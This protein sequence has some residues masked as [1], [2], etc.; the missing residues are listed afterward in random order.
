[1]KIGEEILFIGLTEQAQSKRSRLRTLQAL[2]RDGCT[3][4]W[5]EFSSL[6]AGDGIPQEIGDRARWISPTPY[7][8]E[9]RRR[10]RQEYPPFLDRFVRENGLWDLWTWRG[11]IGVWWL[12]PISEM[13]PMRTPLI[14]LLY[15]LQIIDQVLAE[16]RPKRVTLLTDDLAV[17]PAIRQLAQRYNAR[18]DGVIRAKR[19]RTLRQSLSQFPWLRRWWF[20]LQ[21]C[22]R[23]VVLRLTGIGKVVARDVAPTGPE[24]GAPGSA[25]GVPPPARSWA[26]FCTLFPSMW[27]FRQPGQWH[28]RS[29]GEW[30][31]FLEDHGYPPV[32]AA[33]TMTH[34]GKILFLS[35]QMRRQMTKSRIILLESQLTFLELLR[36]CFGNSCRRSYQ[37]WRRGRK[38]TAHFRGIEVGPLLMREIEHDI[39][40][41]EIPFNLCAA[42]AIR[43][44]A[45]RLGNI[46]C[47]T[48]PFEYQPTER[49]FTAGL[50]SAQ[51]SVPVIGLQTGLTG[52][53]HLGYRFPRG[54]IRQN[55]GDRNPRL[56]PL[57]DL[58]AVNG[59]TTL[60]ILQE[61]LAPKR[62]VLTG[63]VR[64]G[65]PR[66]LA[67]QGHQF[68]DGLKQWDIDLPKGCLPVLIAT[69]FLRTDSVAILRLAFEAG[70]AFPKTFFLIKDH[71][72]CPVRRE[73]ATIAARQGFHRYGMV[74]S[75]SSNLWSASRATITGTTSVGIEAIAFGS[76]PIVYDTARHYDQSP[77]WDIEEGVFFFQDAE[78]LRWA[79]SKCIQEEGGVL[80]RK[81][82]WPD[83]LE[84]LY[85]SSEVNPC[86]TLYDFLITSDLFPRRGHPLMPKGS[87]PGHASVG[88]AS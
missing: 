62:V 87:T 8:Q 18:L 31:K 68:E 25:G 86:S 71:P 30:P 23:W 73:A 14:H 45:A 9:A 70:K 2:Q 48:I 78:S 34:A 29:F 60:N 77:M 69:T 4:Q 83:L 10:I 26:L 88:A 36:F 55:G 40:S 35:R 63:P 76:M 81:N 49:A 56:A 64:L 19:R 46:G 28:N 52:Q 47:M 1:M 84:R 5:L 54:Q 7:A 50:K 53:N 15:R 37:S 32:F 61:R 6:E 38:R 85:Y 24:Q 39:Q 42:E 11:Q 43:R 13:S 67:R 44:L 3:V 21:Q 27:E 20:G 80:E 17:V 12:M 22:L 66:H 51:P 74:E 57:P 41:P 75:W 59:K 65:H 16:H 72:L 58:I 79:L 33:T 82:R